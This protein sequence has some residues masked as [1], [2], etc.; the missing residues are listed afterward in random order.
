[1]VELDGSD[2][3]QRRQRRRQRIEQ[4]DDAC[5]KCPQRQNQTGNAGHHGDEQSFGQQLPDDAAAAGAQRQTDGDLAIPRKSARQHD[6]RHVGARRD[7][8]QNESRKDRRQGRQHLE[9]Q[10]VGCRVG[11]KVRSHV[12]GGVGLLRHPGHERRERGLRAFSGHVRAKTDADL[13]PARLRQE[14]GRGKRSVGRERDPDITRELVEPGELGREDAHDGESA[15]VQ[16]QL[17]ADDRRIAAEQPR[18]CLMADHDRV[19]GRA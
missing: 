19:A 8:N 18:P 5:A 17:A 3:H 10:R 14:L 15:A 16:I 13:Q 9:R 12:A 4:Q 1:M 11:L 7:Q 6:V 2:P